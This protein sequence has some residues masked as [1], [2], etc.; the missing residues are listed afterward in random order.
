MDPKAW[1]HQT[2]RRWFKAACELAGVELP[3]GRATH[4]LKHSRIA[5][6]KALGWTNK[7]IAD[8][9]ATTSR[10]S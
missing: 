5:E 4:V 1:D 3:P 9:A 8:W 2:Q 10:R 7:Q 6:L